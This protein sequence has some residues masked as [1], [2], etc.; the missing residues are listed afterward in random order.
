MA[1]RPGT[2]HVKKLLKESS[3]A[4]WLKALERYPDAIKAKAKTL[5][6]GKTGGRSP[7]K[8]LIEN[9]KWW[10]TDFGPIM[11]RQGHVTKEQL[12]RLME[13][14]LS[15][16]KMRFS[17]M[18]GVQGNSADSVLS[19]S[20][21]ALKIAEKGSV[22]DAVNV[23]CKLRYV[24]PA[25][26]SGIL[27]AYDPSKFCMMSDEPLEAIMGDRKYTLKY[28]LEYNEAMLAVAAKL[29]MR[30]EEAEMACYSAAWLGFK[31]AI[32][33][34]ESGKKKRPSPVDE[35]SGNEKKKRRK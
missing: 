23:F 20:T 15:H 5:K 9:D 21:Q 29:S 33:G 27:S 7:A 10:R 32:G 22:K 14:K 17:L 31:E 12:V 4:V 1:P 25:T 24:G 16:G 28:Y 26:A 18:K 2:I 11:K 30:V 3:K 13:W 34:A 35:S 6:G 19:C 8:A